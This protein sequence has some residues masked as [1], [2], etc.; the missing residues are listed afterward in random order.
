MRVSVF[1]TALLP[2]LALTASLAACDSS[3]SPGETLDTPLVTVATASVSP[4][5]I[6]Q[7]RAR[8]LAATIWY[9]N[10]CSSPRLQ[11]REG[12]VWVDAPDP[13][14]L[15]SADVQRLNGGETVDIGV[16][17]PMGYEI[18]TYRIVFRIS[19]LD[20]VDAAP[21]TNTFEVQ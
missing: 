9:Y 5:A 12:D 10:A 14:M 13:L 8:N 1:R 3:L 15:C 16:G 17:V 11:R 4:G 7:F 19:R 6:V 2:A 20:G 21:T 18:G